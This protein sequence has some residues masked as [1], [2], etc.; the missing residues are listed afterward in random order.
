MFILI[1]EKKHSRCNFAV[2]L[3]LRNALTLNNL[4]IEHIQTKL[5]FFALYYYYVIF[6]KYY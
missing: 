4:Y 1:V 2:R 5:I 3:L 6:I